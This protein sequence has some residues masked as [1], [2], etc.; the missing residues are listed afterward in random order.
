MMQDMLVST[1]RASGQYRA[2]SRAGS[3]TRGD[4][5]V[6][7]HLFAL[8]EIDKPSMAARFSLQIELFDPKS[9]SVVWTASYSHD[10]PVKGKR[11]SD[12]VE[13]LDSNVQTGLQQLAAGLAQFL[14]NRPSS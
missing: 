8:D 3:V 7:G 9:G 5:I 14:A 1:L 4:F 2:V 10:E 12:V 11:V 6:R 13:A